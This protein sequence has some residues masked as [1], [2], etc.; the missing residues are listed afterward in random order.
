MQLFFTTSKAQSYFPEL[1]LTNN[2]TRYSKI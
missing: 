1:Y 2:I